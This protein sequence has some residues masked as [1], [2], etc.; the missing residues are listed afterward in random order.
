M[1]KKKKPIIKNNLRFKLGDLG[2]QNT[3]CFFLYLLAFETA[4][5][6]VSWQPHCEYPNPLQWS[7]EHIITSI[8]K[9]MGMGVCF[10]LK[11]SLSKIASE[12]QL[13]GMDGELILPLLNL[14]VF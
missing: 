12:N 8:E 14:D 10:F 6:V 3:G 2:K 5:S 9:V 7:F 1:V 13:F 11:H 4:F